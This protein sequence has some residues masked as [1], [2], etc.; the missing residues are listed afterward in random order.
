MGLDGLVDR[1]VEVCGGASGPGYV[2]AL[3]CMYLGR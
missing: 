1:R 2:C 3:V